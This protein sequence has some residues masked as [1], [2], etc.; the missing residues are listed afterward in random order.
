MKSECVNLSPID[1]QLLVEP[2]PSTS[3]P[4]GF[5]YF[6]ITTISTNIKLLRSFIEPVFALQER[7]IYRNNN[8]PK[9]L[10]SVGVQYLIYWGEKPISG[11][12]CYPNT[13]ELHSRQG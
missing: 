8:S 5:W 12:N 9:K 2:L 13:E 10:D 7:H 4:T 1:I 6:R 11:K 3:K